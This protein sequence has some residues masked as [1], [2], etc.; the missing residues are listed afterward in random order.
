MPQNNGF[1]QGLY[2]EQYWQFYID[3]YFEKQYGTAYQLIGNKTAAQ[4]AIQQVC[5]ATIK[6]QDGVVAVEFK[7]DEWLPP[8]PPGRSLNLF[9]ETWSN[10]GWNVKGWFL[11]KE[12]DILFY[13]FPLF[14]IA[15]EGELAGIKDWVEHRK[16]DFEEKPQ[17]R[18]RQ[19]ND[20]WGLLV[21]VDRLLDA[22]VITE[23]DLSEYIP[24]ETV[25]KRIREI[26]TAKAQGR[27]IRP[28]D[29]AAKA[30]PIYSQRLTADGRITVFSTSTA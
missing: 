21:P 17:A 20:A 13:M 9:C 18:F 15:Y 12:A 27:P 25:T 8:Q 16:M 19:K 11:T 30:T 2:A 3:R 22:R 14:R 5:D 26:N 1:Q 28:Q 23:I 10:R 7:A 24:P 29:G 4:R 6:G